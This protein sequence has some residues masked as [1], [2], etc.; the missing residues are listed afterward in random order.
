MLEMLAQTLPATPLPAEDIAEDEAPVRTRGVAESVRRLSETPLLGGLAEAELIAVVRA[1]RLRVLE[2]GEIAV[3]EGEPGH[4]LFVIMDG[5][6]R[7]FVRNPSGRSFGAGELG[8]GDFFGEIGSLSGRA[9]SATIVA[10][11]RSELLELDKGAVDRIARTHPRVREALEAAYIRRASS[12]EAAAIRAVAV[13]AESRD[14]AIEVLEAYFGESRWEPRM[15]LR[16][17]D[18]LVRTGKEDEA[19]PLLVG[20]AAE[21]DRAGYPEKAV[22]I[23]KKIEGIKRRNVEEV[24]L[25]PLR[26]GP[27][28]HGLRTRAESQP[29]TLSP[30]VA[31]SLRA[32]A[33]APRPGWRGKSQ[34]RLESWILDMAR[35]AAGVEG[36]REAE[37]RGAPV[38]YASGLRASPLFEG[39]DEGALAD[40]IRELRLV[41]ASAGDV[42]LTEGEPGHSLFVIAAGAVRV[43]VKGEDGKSRKVADLPSGSFFGEIA[44][45]SGRPRTATVTAAAATDL[46][47]IDRPALDALSAK[48][49]RVREIIEEH[50]IARAARA[51]G[52]AH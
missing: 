31:R 28:A 18:L 17:A 29:S 37:S 38:G 4:S 7:V 25:A 11:Q 44:A 43:Y 34:D 9:R 41:S 19:V 46:L 48:H 16:L 30:E 32:E 45:L 39:F 40:L 14:R 47:E 1:M 23:L 10:A 15:R 5:R 13:D 36:E 20:L 3:T 27:E 2:P 50:Y 33:A 21:M 22:A 52:A 35:H 51:G 6:L 24:N 8:A 26:K 42:I 12:P 49:P